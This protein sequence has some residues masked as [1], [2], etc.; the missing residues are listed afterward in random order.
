MS[1]NCVISFRGFR[2]GLGAW[3]RCIDSVYRHGHGEREARDVD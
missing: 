1:C 2:D 3:I